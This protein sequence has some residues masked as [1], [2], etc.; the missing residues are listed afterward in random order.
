MHCI[1]TLRR[2]C[3]FGTCIGVGRLYT[4]HRRCF[5]VVHAAPRHARA[6]G[7]PSDGFPHPPPSL[8]PS[9]FPLMPAA[10]HHINASEMASTL[11][12]VSCHS[13]EGHVALPPHRHEPRRKKGDGGEKGWGG[14][15]TYLT[16]L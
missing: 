3:I 11:S 10:W 15:R 4:S 12:F 13:C 5:R 1:G 16:K 6:D 2:T 14:G 9:P 7:L 8:L